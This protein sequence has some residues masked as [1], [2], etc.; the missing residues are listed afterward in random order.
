[1]KIVL[2]GQF[3]IQKTTGQQRYAKEI[4]AELDKII[5]TNEVSII[6][7]QNAFLPNYKNIRVIRFGSLYNRLWEQICLPFYLW[8]NRCK[9]LSFCNT[10]PILRPGPTVIH[11]TIIQEHPEYFTTV[12]GK[13][14]RFYYNFIFNRITKSRMPVITVTEYSKE[15]IHR[16]HDIPYENIFVIGNAWQHFERIRKNENFFNEHTDIKPNEFFFA[17]GSLARQKNFDWIYKNAKLYPN[18][19]YIIAG[20][21]VGNYRQS[22][23]K[24]K[25]ITYLGYISD[26]DIKTLMA[27]C[28]S[29]IFPSIEEGFGIPPL[30]ALS[31][32]A[33]VIASNTSCLPEVLGNAVYYINPLDNTIDLNKL[34]D[35]PIDKKAIRLTLDKYSWQESAKKIYNFIKYCE[36]NL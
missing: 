22:Q 11:D 19:K 3:F 1:M 17:L 15:N 35:I 33:K 32:G 27:S 24:L 28:K 13:F 16:I 26:E 12:K 23:E 30:E 36:S 34:I 21:P 8:K 25:N 18:Q 9:C 20:K 4:L 2:N 31:V 5:S 6:V 14:V 29:F 10:T 7:P